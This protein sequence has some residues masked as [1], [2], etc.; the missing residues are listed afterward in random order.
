MAIEVRCDVEGCESHAP[1]PADA[2]DRL[3]VGMIG[4]PKGW[5]V[6][7][8]PPSEVDE[9]RHR[10]KVE[11]AMGRFGRM[12]SPALGGPF[13]GGDVPV[14]PRR[15]YCCDKHEMPKF[16]PSSMNDDG[17]PGGLAPDLPLY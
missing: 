12:G 3:M 8:L 7:M 6:V 5:T 15:V 10:K 14:P 1:L 13:G 17:A 11:A 16:R 9:Q 4:I 2:M